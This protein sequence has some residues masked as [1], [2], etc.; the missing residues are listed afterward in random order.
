MQPVVD[1]SGKLLKVKVR[2]FLF[3]IKISGDK[4][5]EINTLDRKI[6]YN[7]MGIYWVCIAWGWNVCLF[8]VIMGAKYQ[9][10]EICVGDEYV[11]LFSIAYLN[12]KKQPKLSSI[13]AVILFRLQVILISKM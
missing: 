13:Y 12:T 10:A 8:P 3:L 5:S 6:Y 4:D 9:E 7:T 11:I 1:K 2:C